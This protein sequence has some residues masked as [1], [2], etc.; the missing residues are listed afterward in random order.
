MLKNLKN[1]Y[2]TT[3]LNSHEYTPAAH[4]K[5]PGMI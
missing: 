2:L 4:V 5:M 1:V 3:D